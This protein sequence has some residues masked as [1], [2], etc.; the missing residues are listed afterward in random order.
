M[1]K[2]RL[3]PAGRIILIQSLPWEKEIHEET[4]SIFD[5]LPDTDDQKFHNMITNLFLSFKKLS[6][7]LKRYQKH[8]KKLLD[9]GSSE[10][11]HYLPEIH[12]LDCQGRSYVLELYDPFLLTDLEVF[13]TGVKTTLDILVQFFDYKYRSNLGKF[14]KKGKS[15][16]NEIK[17][18]KK[19]INKTQFSDFIN[20]NSSFLSEVKT[21]RDKVTHYSSL[22]PKKTLS[23]HYM[24]DETSKSKLTRINDMLEPLIEIKEGQFTGTKQY[25][26]DVYK[27]TIDFCAEFVTLCYSN[28]D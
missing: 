8:Y 4:R 18:N 22:M 1:T 19:V 14:S 26:S 6:V 10:L 16:L 21:F 25:L 12:S 24:L 23:F 20:Q 15:L 3:P 17:R 5:R 2:H 13:F 9:D 28:T 11:E 27:K 7:I